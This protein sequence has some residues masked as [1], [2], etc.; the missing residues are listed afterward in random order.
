MPA[1]PA[2]PE[3]RRRR[4]LLAGV[5]VALAALAL[6]VWFTRGD[7]L[8]GDGRGEDGRPDDGATTAAAPREA[9]VWRT[10]ADGD[11]R[12]E[13]VATV[14]PSPGAAAEDVV[15]VDGADEAQEVRGF[16]AALTQSS[17]AL[18][19][20][21]SEEARRALLTELF[22]PAGPTR[23]SVL[24]LPLGGSD[25]V[26]DAARTYDD[27]PPGETDWDL[28][29]FSTAGDEPGVRSLLR[30]IRALA[31]EL[32]VV[33]SPWSP[34]AWLKTSGSLV[35]GRLLDDDRAY[36]TYA[37]YLVQ[38]LQEYAAAGV[39]IDALTV[40]NEPQARHPDGYPGTDMPVADQV[41]LV[42][43]LG[44][45]LEE[46]GLETQLLAFD[47]NWSLHPGD[48]AA[49]PEGADPEADY[50]AQVLRS[51]A[52]PWLDGVAFH[53]YSGDASAQDAIRDEF[54]GLPIWVTECSGSH[55]PGTP[56]DQVFADT[57]AW[58]ARNLLVGS[59]AHG[60]TAVLTW[61]LA[62]DTDGGP[63]VGG[64]ATCTGVVTVDGDAVSR[65]AERDVLAHAARFVPPG[66]VRVASTWTADDAVVQVAFRTP[67]GAVVVL[68]QNDGDER[69]VAVEVDD[70]RFP[71]VLAARSLTTVVV[72][73]P[74]AAPEPVARGAL[75]VPVDLSHAADAADVPHAAVSAD[76][77]A[78]SDPCCAEDVAARA[79]DGDPSTRWSSGRPQRAGDALQ[80]DLGEPVA[81]RSVVLDAGGGDWPRGYE[82]LVSDDGE[83]WRGP[84]AAGAG[85]GAV[86]AATLDG[87]E[88]RHL[89]VR[90][91]ADADPWWSVAELRVFS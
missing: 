32:V 66:S 47:H 30:E 50:A 23:L 88:V 57:L 26:V 20:A 44:P 58:Q 9:E 71:V 87:D 49:T 68:A 55:A 82:V 69:P 17:A 63:H 8:R 65:N 61:N 40:Q 18:L 19:L 52:A 11:V 34:P 25:F 45:A 31:P 56:P 27:L 41:R 12:L 72:G 37:A 28:E 70:D 35:G 21:M 16:G 5:L 91:T 43:E 81:V 83:R 14:A 48:A 86:T 59:L 3:A 36:R 74:G 54:P 67:A 80:V 51:A 1:G 60:A 33:A 75:P 38:A 42:G 76:P 7:G 46:A 39:P 2:A 79:V 85:A 53:C 24:R 29:R 4:V 73:G 10:T 62:L 89:R 13:R 15:A 78:P 6:A 22:D 77:P 64:C 84:V 90:L